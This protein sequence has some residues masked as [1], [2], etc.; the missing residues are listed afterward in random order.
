MTVSLA[1]ALRLGALDAH[2]QGALV[3]RGE[4]SASEIVEAAL[5]RIDHVDPQVNA[6]T[7]VDREAPLRARREGGPL[8]GVPYLLKASLE[9]PGWPMTSCSRA[10]AG[11]IGRTA[12]PF[13]RSLDTAGLM[14]VG[15]TA[16]P[17]FGLLTG[18]EPMLTG[19]VRNP[20]CPG[21]SAG[22]SSTGAAAAVAAGLVPLAHASDAAGSIRV[23]TASCGVVG[24]KSTRGANLR[25]RAPHV[26]DDLLCCDGLIGR[27]VRDVAWA[28]ETT[29]APDG[30]LADALPVAGL[31]VALC[32]TGLDGEQP[33]PDVRD[34]TIAAG[35]LCASLGC[36]VEEVRLPVDGAS[37]I[38]AFKTIWLHE[39]GE[40][41]DLVAAANPAIPLENLLEPWT[42]GLA[43]RRRTLGLLDTGAAFAQVAES[44]E[45]L[46]RLF[47][48]Y[49]I[50][51]SP[52]TATPPPA[53]GTFDPGSDFDALWTAFWRYTSF[54]PLQNIA[55]TPAISLPLGMSGDGRPVG[56]MFA[57][58]MGGDR[59]LLALAA[60]LEEA[61]PWR[62]RWPAL[63]APAIAGKLPI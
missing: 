1:D 32:L 22:G 39:G 5:M 19:A 27:S 29:R 13:V 41:A 30:G 54:T 9:Y 35:R 12:Y 25:A 6:V 2:D 44:A 51:L 16:M 24:L 47:D 43:E 61:C 23:P 40:I 4:V 36:A 34:A 48:R 56:A 63:S 15:M 3:V 38:A 21:H 55:G 28:L 57:A 52:V 18:G 37:I 7:Y 26:I 60:A 50:V 17:E 62:D 42:L 45:A 53:L 31:R 8:A 14:P 10:R 49:D 59:T 33:A 58:G 11:A 46:A 20:W